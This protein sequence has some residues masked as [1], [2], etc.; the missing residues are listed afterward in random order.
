MEK[1]RALI[2]KIIMPFVRWMGTVIPPYS[3]K[4]AIKTYY[5][6]EHKIQPLDIILC[7]TAG[8]LSNVFNRGKWKHVVV[9][10]GWE[11]STP[12]VVEALGIGVIKR[13]LIECLAEKDEVCIVRYKKR[14]NEPYDLNKGI[15]FANAQIGKS[16][17]LMF[18]N[19]S[20]HKF[21]N[22]FCSELGYFSLLQ[23]YPTMNFTMR[24]TLGVPTVTPDDFYEASQIENPKIE[25]VY[26]YK[27]SF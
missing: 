22:L 11:N 15:E 21:D 3:V 10:T 6:W 25:V 27:Y 14:A 18:D 20:E 23:A 16:Y 9:F 7:N 1:I 24:N 19:V 8:H 4:N 13:P 2:L 17:D 12:M 5:D 26:E